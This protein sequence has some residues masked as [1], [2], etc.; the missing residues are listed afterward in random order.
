MP[1]E[2]NIAPF[3]FI[4]WDLLNDKIEICPY[5]AEILAFTTTETT[6]TY[7][8]YR[9][10]THPEDIIPVETLAKKL[11][12]INEEYIIVESR[13][14]CR[15]GTWRWFSL[16]GKVIKKD[17]DGNPLQA[18]GILTDINYFK[19]AE[20]KSQQVDL[21]FSEMNRIKRCNVR[22]EKECRLLNDSFKQKC[23][24]AFVCAEILK[25]LEKITNSSNSMFIFSSEN[26]FDKQEIVNNALHDHNRKNIDLLSLPTKNSVL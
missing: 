21:L 6:Q 10:L 26:I 14:L 13:K 20:A 9:Q 1:T 18:A 25:S 24:E 16:H 3:G 5:L 8:A 2:Q 22:C 17:K 7:S 12:E 4:Q 15:D 19:E 11:K 23:A